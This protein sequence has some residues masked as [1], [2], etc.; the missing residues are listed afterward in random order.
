MATIQANLRTYDL[1][2]AP[3]GPIWELV[4]DGQVIENALAIEVSHDLSSIGIQEDRMFVSF[5]MPRKDIVIQ[6]RP[7]E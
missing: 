3:P 6:Q 5:S 4:V 7:N 2:K 1:E